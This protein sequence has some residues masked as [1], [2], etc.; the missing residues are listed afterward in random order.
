MLQAHVLVE[1][2]SNSLVQTVHIVS[3]YVNITYKKNIAKMFHLPK[4]VG[5]LILTNITYKTI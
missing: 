3:L 1:N 2:P 5:N 4:M